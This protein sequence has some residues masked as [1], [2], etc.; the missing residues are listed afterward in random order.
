MKYLILSCS[1]GGGHLSAAAA[2]A[3][4]MINRGHEVDMF[5]PYDLM[6]DTKGENV[7]KAYVKLVQKRPELFGVIYKMGEKVSKI[8]VKSPVYFA[9]FLETLKMRKYLSENKYDGIIM[10]HIYPGEMITM[11]KTHGF[12]LPPTYFIATDYVCIPFT[13]EICPDYFFIPGEDQVENFV[14]NK[15]PIEKIKS[16]GIPVKEEFERKCLSGKGYTEE[17]NS[18]KEELGLDI[19]SRYILVCGGSVGAG[20]I[21]LVTEMLG[22]YSKRRAQKIE[23]NNSTKRKIK[24]I[25]VCGNNEKL[26]KEIQLKANE[27]INV[28]STTDKMAKY[29]K[30]SD[31]VISK[32]GGLSSTEAVVSNVPLIHISPIPGCETYNVKY[33]SSNGISNYVRFTRKE[34][35]P[36]I[37]RLL[38]KDNRKEMRKIQ[39]TKINT[40]ARRDICDFI[41]NNN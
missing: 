38:L 15:I 14:K 37:N 3:E 2:I 5:D 33:F 7:G 18:L 24:A 32:P 19:E 23:E 4:E 35:I 36:T 12:D 21:K 41:E 40:N 27:N 13:S 31:I 34:L 8:P 9:N 28:L 20:E 6:S 16:F 25:V 1:T 30:A 26:Y 10:S 11:L 17:K 39:R 29:L 22:E